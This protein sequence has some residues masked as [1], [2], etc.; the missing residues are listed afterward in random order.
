MPEDL[1]DNF[2]EEKTNLSDYKIKS[3]I[4][5]HPQVERQIGLDYIDFNLDWIGL[6]QTQIRFNQIGP[7]LDKIK[8]DD[9]RL[10]LDQTTQTRLDQI[11]S[12]QIRVD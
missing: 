5:M 8:S 7:N 2:H 10:D 3:K 9:I 6:D 4:G 1:A 12:G 11:T